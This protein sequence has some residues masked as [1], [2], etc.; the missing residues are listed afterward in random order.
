[1]API[2]ASTSKRESALDPEPFQSIVGRQEQRDAHQEDRGVEYVG[3][4]LDELADPAVAGCAQVAD[5][6]S[7]DVVARV[8]DLGQGEEEQRTAPLRR[9][10]ESP[11]ASGLERPRRS[12]GPNA[13]LRIWARALRSAIPL[14]G[15][16][17][18]PSVC[19]MNR[20]LPGKNAH[21]QES[22]FNTEVQKV[23]LGAKHM[24]D[25]Q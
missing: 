3:R 1:M 18:G 20:A 14:P 17:A 16:H 7:G 4:R 2:P 12:V 10:R 11:P 13:C 21:G 24:A 6:L 15:R 25:F 8:V 23:A 22:G 9:R 5:R 19:V